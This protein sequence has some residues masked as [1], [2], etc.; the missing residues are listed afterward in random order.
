MEVKAAEKKESTCDS[1]APEYKQ[2][3]VFLWLQMGVFSGDGKKE[4]FT[5][6]DEIGQYSNLNY[7]IR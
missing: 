5:H 4:G 7:Q 3:M 2:L 1:M 6:I